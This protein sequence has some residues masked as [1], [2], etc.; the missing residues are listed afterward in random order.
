MIDEGASFIDLGAI[1]TRPGAGELTLDI[2]KKRLLPI[3]EKLLIKIP[4][5]FIF[6]RY[7]SIRNSR[8]IITN[9]SCYYK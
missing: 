1:S 2:E 3:L 9:G 7:F 4:R 6:Y 8:R 5:L